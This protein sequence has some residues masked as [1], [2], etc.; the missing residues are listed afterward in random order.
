MKSAY[1]L[2]IV[3]PAL[4]LAG[5]SAFT[6]RS[7]GVVQDELTDCPSWPRCVSSATNA[8]RRVEPFV[9]A[10]P[11][12][13]GWR[14]ARN[15]VANMERTTVVNETADYLHAEIKSPWN[16]YTDDLELLL[17]PA[18]A[19]QAARIEVRSSGRIGYFDF[20]VNR[21]RVEGLR[22]SLIQ[23]GVVSP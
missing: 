18:T 1:L 6:E 14:I 17:K 4:S 13:R 16:F 21:E 23:K 15:A 5:C 10:M 8:E 19:G 22:Q 20:H 7:T 2:L 3:L 12:E 9:L 11:A